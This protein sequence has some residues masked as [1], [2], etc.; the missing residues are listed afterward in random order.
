MKEIRTVR[1]AIPRLGLKETMNVVMAIAHKS[2]YETKPTRTT[3][4]L[5]DKLWAALASPPPT[6][7]KLIGQ[8]LKLAEDVDVLFLMGL[9]H[10]IGKT[11]LRQGL[12]RGAGGQGPG[13]E[14]RAWPTSRRP[15]SASSYDHAQALGLQRGLHPGR[16]A[17]REKRVR[18]RRSPRTAWSSTWPTWSP[19]RSAT[20]CMEAAKIDPAELALGPG[21]LGIAPEPSREDRARTPSGL[22]KELA[23]L[24]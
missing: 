23:H 20:A 10:D 9:T 11:F 8:H 18:R 14:A 24:F 17:A 3:D 2:L 1:Q 6:A 12:F 4:F 13:H 16:F 5:M 21:L 22:V 19:A 15:T 7:A